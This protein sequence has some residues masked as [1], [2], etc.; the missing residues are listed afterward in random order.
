MN[1]T[2]RRLGFLMT[3][4][5]TLTIFV[6]ALALASEQD[7]ADTAH[8]TE[9]NVSVSS[10]AEQAE[11][12]S[13]GFLESVGNFF[14]GGYNYVSGGVGSFA[15]SAVAW[16]GGQSGDEAVPS[17]AESAAPE[18]EL[19]ATPA[20][21]PSPSAKS[22][23]VSTLS[24]NTLRY[25]LGSAVNTGKDN[26]YSGSKAIELDDPHFGWTLGRFSVSGYTRVTEDVD[27]DPV[28]LKTLG[29]KVTLWFTLEQDIDNLNGN[30]KLK[31]TPHNCGF[32]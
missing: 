16:I 15:S 11:T 32:C 26:G 6:S 2:A 25:Y 21:S 18:T 9:A 23:A 4:L 5:F 8:S 29:D 28:F 31:A 3:V 13:S 24:P 1:K 14:V 17:A 7:N 20:P 10:Q 30:D 19:M 22:S 12:G 27:G